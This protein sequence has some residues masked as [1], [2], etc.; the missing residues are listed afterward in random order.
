[1]KSTALLRLAA[2]LGLAVPIGVHAGADT[3]ASAT[4][5]TG[6]YIQPNAVSLL[7]YTAEGGEPGHRPGG[8]NGSLKSAWWK[9]TAPA[10]GF[11]TED[12]MT[13]SDSDYIRDTLV[14]IYTGTA[15]NDLTRITNNDDTGAHLLYI[16]GNTSSVTFYAEEGTTYH[17]AVDGYS[18]SSITASAHKTQLRLRLLRSVPEAYYGVFGSFNEALGHGSVQVNKTAGHAFSGKIVVAGKSLPFKGVFTEDGLA[19]FGFE[20]KIT[21]GKT[22]L[23]PLTL[24]LDGAAGGNFAVVSNGDWMK[25]RLHLPKKF[26]LSSTNTMAG[27]YSAMISRP[28]GGVNWKGGA[29]TFSTSPKGAVVAAAVLPD[30]TKMTASSWLCEKDASSCWVPIYSSLHK[31]RGFFLCTLRVTEAGAVDEVREDTSWPNRYLRPANPGAPFMPDEFNWSGSLTVTGATYTPPPA[32]TRV[33]GFLDGTAGAGAL[34]IP[35]DAGEL[36]PA[37][38]ENLTFNTTNTFG[39]SSNTRKPVLKLNKA[40][41]LVTGSVIDNGGLK[42]NL[43][44]I[45]FLDGMTPKLHG[46]ASGTTK[47]VFFEVIP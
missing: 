37:I 24:Q 5:I 15:V 43:T 7:S 3:F 26:S 34:S 38:T 8:S 35:M 41:G 10:T 22:P 16:A 29:L 17:I 27:R 46:H 19:T 31:N 33:L 2:L 13:W 11:C 40:T 42:R 36:N 4:T 47:N 1:M 39:F 32:N 23:P 12:T 20:G 25:G 14:G 30:G 9:W 18:G 6:T 28:N 44:G 21:P 45:L